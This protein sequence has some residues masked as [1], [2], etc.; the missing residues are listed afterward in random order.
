M[1]MTCESNAI[2]SGGTAYFTLKVKNMDSRGCAPTQF[3][4]QAG[5]YQYQVMYMVMPGNYVWQTMAPEQSF[6]SKRS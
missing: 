5:A 1:A 6:D 2:Q 4:V 3:M